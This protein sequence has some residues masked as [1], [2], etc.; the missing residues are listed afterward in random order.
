M[1]LVGGLGADFDWGLSAGLECG[2]G[3]GFSLVG[4]YEGFSDV[5]VLLWHFFSIFRV[6]EVDF[7]SSSI[8]S[9]CFL[10]TPFCLEFKDCSFLLSPSR[11]AIS[12]FRDRTA[13]RKYSTSGLGT[14]TWS[15]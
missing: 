8:T 1:G 12:S 2:L 14:S 6:L 13:D 3:A 11:V 4:V 15:S 7:L 9:F 5:D 10:I